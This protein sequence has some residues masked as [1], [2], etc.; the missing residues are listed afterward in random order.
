MGGVAYSYI[1]WGPYRPSTA[2][3][4]LRPASGSAP[5]R[6]PGSMPHLC[7]VRCDCLLVRA[8]EEEGATTAVT[9][10]SE[11]DDGLVVVTH[12]IGGPHHFLTCIQ[13]EGDMIEPTSCSRR[14]PDEAQIVMVRSDCKE[15]GQ[16]LLG[17]IQ[18]GAI[19]IAK[20]HM[21]LI[22]FATGTNLTRIQGDMVQTAGGSPSARILL[23]AVTQGAPGSG[24][25]CQ[26]STSQNTSCRCPSGER[27]R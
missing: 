18:D 27:K 25:A 16:F 6:V 1:D 8:G 15:G 7:A 11:F 12:Q 13:V 20:A 24:G 22:E 21:L 26:R 23:W 3:D 5:N 4:S 14:V 2:L 10:R 17:S 19:V 9:P